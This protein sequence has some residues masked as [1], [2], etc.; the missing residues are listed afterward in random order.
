[1]KSGLGKAKHQK[2]QV[3]GEIV[4]LVFDLDLSVVIKNTID[5]GKMAG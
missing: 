5:T 2:D 1:L 3:Q 4:F